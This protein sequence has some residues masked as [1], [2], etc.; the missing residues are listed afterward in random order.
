VPTVPKPMTAASYEG[1]MLEGGD[2][3]E[4][5]EAE[6]KRLV[7]AGVL[8][9]TAKSKKRSKMKQRS[10]PDVNVTACEPLS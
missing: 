4:L 6:G 2:E 7:E 8:E 5:P 9:E 1:R 3:V 10:R